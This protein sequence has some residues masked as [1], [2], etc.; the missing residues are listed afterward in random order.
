MKFNFEVELGNP[1]GTPRYVE[2][3]VECFYS[4]HNDGIGCY[5]YWGHKCIDKGTDYCEID[6]VVWDHSNYTVDEIAEIEVAIQ[7][8]KKAWSEKIMERR[9]ELAEEYDIDDNF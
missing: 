8:N 1:D 7:N 2:I 4:I 9:S 6:D 5:E 3:E